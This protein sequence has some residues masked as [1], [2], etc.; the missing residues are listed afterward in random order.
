MKVTDQTVIVAADGGG[1]GCRAA[2]G[3]LESGMLAQASG[4]PGNVHSNFDGA[5]SNLTSAIEAALAQAGLAGTPQD[6][7][8]AHLGVAG[9][10]SKVEMAAVAA[11]LPYGRSSVTGDRATSVRGVLGDA[12]G[13]VVALG[14]GTIVARQKALEMRTVG[15][16]GFDLSD[17]ASGAWLGLR[18]LQELILAEDGLRPHTDLSRRVLETKGGLIQVVHFSAAAAPGD[19]AVLARDVITAAKEG[20]ALAQALM[21]EGAAYLEQ[22]LDTLGFQTGDLLSLAGGVG[23]HY[24]EFLPDRMTGNLKAPKGTALEGAFAIAAQAARN[25]VE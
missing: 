12:D 7:I 6:Q 16:W 23:P 8:T 21:R 25:A 2:A 11:A 1:T 24:A 19:Y 20:D 17:Q 13:Y 10:H 9:A 18:L 3:T 5:I 4:G 22:G 15:G 14:T